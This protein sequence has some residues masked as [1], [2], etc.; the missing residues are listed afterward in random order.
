VRVV[1]EREIEAHSGHLY[2]PCGESRCV[3]GWAAV[4]EGAITTYNDLG[5][6]LIR[7][8]FGA[9]IVDAAREELD[10]MRHADD[11]RCESVYYEG[12]VRAHIASQRETINHSDKL[13]DSQRLAIGETGDEL[14]GIDPS[15][16]AQFVRK[17]MGFVPHHEKL[18]ALAFDKHLLETLGQLIGEPPELFQDM[19]MIKPPQGREKPWHQDHAYFN[20]PLETEVVGVWISLTEVTPE[21]GGMYLLPGS[22]RRGPVPHF[23]R[24]DWQICDSDLDNFAAQGATVV[25]ASMQPGDALLFSS[26]LPHGTPTNRSNCQRWALQFHYRACG[27]AECS[28]ETRLALFGSEGKEVS[29]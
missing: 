9:D 12:S 1:I 10:R 24:R 16:R 15:I 26:K 2:P 17:F 8:A 5:Y 25:T 21:S 11:P 6:L 19:A 22:H 23:M 3:T 13:S 28:D 20:L 27:V 18:A 4:T 14:P 29:C 7:G